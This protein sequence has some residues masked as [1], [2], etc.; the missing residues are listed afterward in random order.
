M[1]DSSTPSDWT[2]AALVVVGHGS[3][4]NPNSSRPTRDHAEAIRR[5]NLFAHVHVAFWK[6]A[7]RLN[8]VLETVTVKDVFVVPNLAC[9]GYIT[10][11]V[12]PQ[13]MGLT[14]PV[15]ERGGRIHGYP[16]REAQGFSF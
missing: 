7:P 2:H 6:E 1:D 15:T 14:G 8:E 5:R 9:K 13:E 10:G 11:D 12:I 3:A 16:V 4:K